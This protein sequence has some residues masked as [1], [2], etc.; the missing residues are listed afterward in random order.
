MGERIDMPRF[1]VLQDD[2]LTA[3][4][5]ESGCLKGEVHTEPPHGSYLSMPFEENG[6]QKGS[7]NEPI[8]G[9]VTTMKGRCWVPL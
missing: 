1:Y 9:K 5:Q 2:F 6:V 8:N 4:G 3:T 7:H